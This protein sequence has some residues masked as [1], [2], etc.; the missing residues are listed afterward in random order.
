[1]QIP[2]RIILQKANNMPAYVLVLIAD[3]Y[4]D[5]KRYDVAL[6]FYLVTQGKLKDCDVS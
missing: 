5:L 6:Q 1:M 3:F 2:F 4:F